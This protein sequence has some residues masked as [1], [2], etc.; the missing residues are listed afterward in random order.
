[1]FKIFILLF[2]LCLTIFADQNNTISE[3]QKM[4]DEVLL[5]AIAMSQFLQTIDGND[6]ITEMAIDTY[7][8]CYIEKMKNLVANDQNKTNEQKN[9]RV[10]N[11]INSVDYYC[12][13]SVYNKY[14]LLPK[15]DKVYEK[16]ILEVIK[17]YV[18]YPVKA[19]RL[20]MTGTVYIGFILSKSGN[21]H[22]LRV[23]K[24]SKFDTLDNAAL[25]SIKKAAPFFPKPPRTLSFAIPIK[26]ELVD[27]NDNNVTK[28]NVQQ[29]NSLK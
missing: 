22:A 2:S 16:E 9:E 4:Q 1:M 14:S 25:S 5:H 28:K 11:G 23:E 29:K 3:K 15:V 6:S 20:R 18:V 7:T 19:R 27:T 24:S 26:Y 12:F 8:N 17:K 10:I 13:G 21:L